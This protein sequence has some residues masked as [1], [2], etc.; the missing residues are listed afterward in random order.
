MLKVNLEKTERLLINNEVLIN[1]ETLV[2]NVEKFYYLTAIVGTGHR[3]GKEKNMYCTHHG[4]A[5]GITNRKNRKKNLFLYF[6]PKLT[7]M[8]LKRVI[9]LNLVQLPN[10]LINNFRQCFENV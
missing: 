4:G 5:I 8:L 3:K 9:T 7:S 2:N 10:Y 6:C 1:D